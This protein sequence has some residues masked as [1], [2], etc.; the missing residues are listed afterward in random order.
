MLTF[1]NS[2]LLSMT[3]IAPT[4]A[5]ATLS[6]Q[7]RNAAP[8]RM[9][10]AP[11]HL[12]SSLRLVKREG[13]VVARF[14]FVSR[15]AKIAECPDSDRVNFCQLG[16]GS[17]VGIVQFA[18]TWR[19][20]RDQVVPAGTYVVRYAIQPRLKDHIGTT[21]YRDFLVLD[22]RG[23]DQHPFVM[24][25]LPASSAAGRPTMNGVVMETE[26]GAIRAG[27]VFEGTGNLEGTD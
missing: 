4:V 14:W 7:A 5:H 8:P 20:Y 19:D 10:G 27:I 3:L 1:T 6:V 25:L 17:T 21:K 26:I 16:A 12:S 11:P 18:S 15:Q 9:A 13:V 24:A 22:C 2:L 23:P